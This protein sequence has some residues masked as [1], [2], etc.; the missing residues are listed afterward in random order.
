MILMDKLKLT[1]ADILSQSERKFVTPVPIIVP[2]A[3]NFY[4]KV[5]YDESISY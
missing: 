3:L 1:E 4:Y 2:A 5:I